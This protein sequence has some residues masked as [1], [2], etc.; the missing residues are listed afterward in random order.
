MLDGGIFRKLCAIAVPICLS[1]ILQQ[2]FNAS[3]TAVVGNFSSSQAMAAVGANAPVI[4]VIVT[5]F[6]GLSIGSNVM[7]A[8]FIGS[9]KR[10][11]VNEALHTSFSV[12][13]VSGFIMLALGQMIAKPVLTLLDTPSDVMG[14]AVTYLRIYFLGMPFL[15]IY[16]FGSAVLRS[17]GDTKRP[18]IYLTCS[19]LLNVCLNLFFVIVLHRNADGVAIA[20]TISNGVSATL[21]FRALLK[22]KGMLH[23]DVRKLGI[24]PEY[25]KKILWIGGPAG[26][27]GMIFSISNVVIQAAINK[28]GSTCI[29]GN[30]AALNFEYI[31]YFVVNGF[32][33]AAMTFI[34]Q[35]FAAKRFDRCRKTTRIAMLCAVGFCAMVA[36][37][38]FLLRHQLIV[39]FSPDPEVIRYAFIRM[40]FITLLE[41]MTASY[42]ITGAS[43]RGIGHSLAPALITLFGS[44]ILRVIYIS[45]MLNR[46]TD[47]RQVV[48]IYPITWTVTGSAVILL[49]FLVTRREYRGAKETA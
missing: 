3:D 25:L 31:S 24:R 44:C 20:T 11:K 32:S 42:E 47:F 26:L 2:L 48:V 34:S 39:L 27:Q 19:G 15:M 37:S 45:A 9:G 41:P 16:D 8:G 40:T 14:M 21:I 4:N 23:L 43:L 38:F 5:L 29:A 30:S 33:Q 13:L 7:L 22:E 46:F 17:I 18:L 12:A 49:Y 36:V 35:N 1:S 10:D 28:F 6:T